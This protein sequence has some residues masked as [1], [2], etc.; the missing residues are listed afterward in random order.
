MPFG[1]SSTCSDN[2]P[3]ELRLH[4]F[5]MLYKEE[6][7]LFIFNFYLILWLLNFMYVCTL[8]SISCELVQITNSI[9]YL[10]LNPAAGL[11]LLAAKDDPFLPPATAATSGLRFTPATGGIAVKKLKIYIHNK[12]FR[13]HQNSKYC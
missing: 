9:L 12:F 2:H 1:P 3:H 6:N 4:F 7:L 8:K 13:C 11:P 10:R 5:K